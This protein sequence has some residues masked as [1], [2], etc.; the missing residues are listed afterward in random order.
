MWF[1]WITMRRL[2]LSCWKTLHRSVSVRPMTAST[3]CTSVWSH[4]RRRSKWQHLFTLIG[5]LSKFYSLS[6][7][8]TQVENFIVIVVYYYFRHIVMQSAITGLSITFSNAK[9]QFFSG[10][11]LIITLDRLWR[12]LP[13]QFFVI[14]DKWWPVRDYTLFILDQWWRFWECSLFSF[15]ANIGI[16]YWMVIFDLRK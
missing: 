14:W 15:L 16:Q 12:N 7:L 3:M 9:W 11:C 6:L 5:R 2:L 4:F 10:L 13:L 8:R 1:S